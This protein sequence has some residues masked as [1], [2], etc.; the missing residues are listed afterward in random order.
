[1]TA[2]SMARLRCG[3]PGQQLQYPGGEAAEC[4]D[5]RP[6]ARRRQALGIRSLKPGSEWYGLSLTLG[7]G[8]MTLLELTTG[9]ATLANRG[10]A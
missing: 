9:Y 5:R 4:G 6:H 1:M 3:G 10:Q 7:G 2:S 8:E